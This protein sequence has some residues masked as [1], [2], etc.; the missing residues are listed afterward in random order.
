MTEPITRLAERAREQTGQLLETLQELADRCNLTDARMAL[1]SHK[2]TL[3]LV[4]QTKTI[5]DRLENP[6][7]PNGTP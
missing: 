5:L 1:T 3:N 2:D 7:G 6:G 4:Q